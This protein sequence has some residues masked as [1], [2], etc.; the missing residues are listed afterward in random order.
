M[1]RLTGGPI[2]RTHRALKQAAAR[3]NP[4]MN[5]NLPESLELAG[6]PT[7]DSGKEIA[8]LARAFGIALRNRDGPRHQGDQPISS[9]SKAPGGA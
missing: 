7:R 5:S 4:L 3:A 9:S 8:P 2:E 6:I 1:P